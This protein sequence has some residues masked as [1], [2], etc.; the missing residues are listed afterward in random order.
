[1]QCIGRFREMQTNFGVIP[2]PKLD[3]AQQK[4]YTY[5]S[6]GVP[7]FAVPITN[8]DLERTGIIAEALAAESSK[9]VI[10]AYIDVAL[11]NKYLRDDD[12]KPMID[13]ILNSRVYDLAYSYQWSS[14][15]ATINN[16]MV[17]N[18]RN[19]VSIYEKNADKVKKAIDATIE[20][21]KELNN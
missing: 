18:D 12:S 1:M 3:E 10:P 16:A 4:Y 11:G 13:I 9:T 20:K 6:N 8:P 17:K 2:F 21:Y 7:L 15:G 5:S 14:I 19:I